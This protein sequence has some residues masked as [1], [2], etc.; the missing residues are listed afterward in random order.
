M[1]G[2]VEGDEVEDLVYFLF[3]SCLLFP[4]VLYCVR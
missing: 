2:V 3:T 4:S 1:E